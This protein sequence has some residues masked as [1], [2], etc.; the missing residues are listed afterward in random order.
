MAG[1]FQLSDGVQVVG[2]GVLRGLSDV[3]V[4]TVITLFA[5]WIVGLPMSYVLGFWLHLNVAGI[6][7]G[8]LAGLTMAAILLPIRFFRLVRKI[9]PDAVKETVYTN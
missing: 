9:K 2:I 1:F 5:Y 8:L 4:P 6:W 3:N 7:I